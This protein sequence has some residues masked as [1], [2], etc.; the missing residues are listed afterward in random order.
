M[1]Q[2]NPAKIRPYLDTPIF[3]KNLA[4]FVTGQESP[5]CHFP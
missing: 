5:K 3:L 4:G 2:T 1:T